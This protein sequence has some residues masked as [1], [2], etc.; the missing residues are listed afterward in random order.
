MTRQP[1]PFDELVEAAYV[2][3]KSKVEQN[4]GEAATPTVTSVSERFTSQ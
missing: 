3:M 1:I 2:E 4:T